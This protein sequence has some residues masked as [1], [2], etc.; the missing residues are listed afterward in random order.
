[1]SE[2]EIELPE[3]NMAVIF[4]VVSQKKDGVRG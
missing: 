3:A 1:M 2:V 4:W